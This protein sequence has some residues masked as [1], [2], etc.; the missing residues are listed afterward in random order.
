MRKLVISFITVLFLIFTANIHQTEAAKLN[1]FDLHSGDILITSNTSSN[2]FT[3]HAGIVT[4][5]GK[6]VV[7]IHP[8]HNKKKPEYM[9]AANWLKS[10]PKTKVV[11]YKD[12]KKANKAGAYAWDNYIKG[13]YKNKTYRITPNV[14]NTNYLYCSEIVWQSYKFGAKVGYDVGRN[15]TPS[16]YT[17][18]YIEPTIIQ[19]YDYT[20]SVL[21][22]HNGFKI[23]KTYKW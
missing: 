23:V 5:N 8:E 9:S 2:G 21:L 22:K 1:G 19:P 10:N 20:H 12:S 14:R 11:R 16:D 18:R 4:G 13:K 7:S 3:G 17:T 15:L 6:N